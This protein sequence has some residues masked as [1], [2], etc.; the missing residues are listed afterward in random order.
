VKYGLTL[1]SGAPGRLRGT[2]IVPD[3]AHT[4][5]QR[6]TSKSNGI[7]LALTSEFEVAAHVAFTRT[8]PETAPTV[9]SY[10]TTKSDELERGCLFRFAWT[11]CNLHRL[12]AVAR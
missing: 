12:P 1:A 8:H 9:G 3:R 10:G 5:D 4:R 2:R 6:L 7:A 11:D